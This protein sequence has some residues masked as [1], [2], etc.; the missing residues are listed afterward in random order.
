MKHPSLAIFGAAA[1][2]TLMVGL[3]SLGCMHTAQPI[4]RAGAVTAA[5]GRAGVA[6][7][8]ACSV[9]VT[10]EPRATLHCRV[11]IQCGERTLFGG[12]MLGGYAECGITEGHYSSARDPMPSKRDGDPMLELD[13]ARRFAR[14]SDD[15]YEVRI[16]LADTP[17]GDRR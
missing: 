9:D 14:V 12:R 5:A 2:L 10:A 8:T 7:G 3:S 17:V 6:V 1:A 4:S 16:E 11:T 15:G 13:V